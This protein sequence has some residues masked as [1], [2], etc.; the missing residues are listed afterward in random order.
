MLRHYWTE[1]LVS[2]DGRWH[3]L[4]RIGL[5][6]MPIQ[7]PIPIWMGSFVGT[8]VERV[9]ERIGRLADGWLPQF[10]PGDELAAVLERLRGYARDAG[11]DPAALGVECAV[12]VAPGD[13]PQRWVETALAYQRLGA[14][15]LKVMTGTGGAANRQP[16]PLSVGAERSLNGPSD[17]QQRVA[18]MTSWRETVGPALSR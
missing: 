14:T 9:I 7:R 3:Q 17:L 2:F 1:E 11:R 5:N 12:R 8:V 4:D 16:D 18:L 6:P 10:P 13:D 15:H